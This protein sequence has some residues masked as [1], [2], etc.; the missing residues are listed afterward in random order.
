MRRTVEKT[1][2]RKWKCQLLYSL[3]GRTLVEVGSRVPEIHCIQ[4]GLVLGGRRKVYLGG[5]A[6]AVRTAGRPGSTRRL[7]WIAAVAAARPRTWLMTLSPK[8]TRN[9]NKYTSGWPPVQL[10]NR[11]VP[12]PRYHAGSRSLPNHTLTASRADT[13]RWWES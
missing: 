9:L 3:D 12:S 5:C 13:E 7:R 8:Q 10:L 1:S 4:T 2:E 11:R 6:E